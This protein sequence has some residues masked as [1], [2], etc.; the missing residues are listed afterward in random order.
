MLAE[1][2]WH[3][4]VVP[5]TPEAQ[6]GHFYAAFG[7]ETQAGGFLLKMAISGPPVPG[8]CYSICLPIPPAPDPIH[9]AVLP[10]IEQ[11]K[12]ASHEKRPRLQL[13][14]LEEVLKMTSHDLAFGKGQTVAGHDPL[15]VASLFL[16]L[17]T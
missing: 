5:K 7:L 10:A 14:D 17:K 9:S 11:G 15:L 2:G 6:K 12:F 13:S 3:T 16:L 8:V 4:T 1:V